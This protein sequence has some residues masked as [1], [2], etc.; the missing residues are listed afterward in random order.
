MHRNEFMYSNSTPFTLSPNK[1]QKAHAGLP[2]I[3]NHSKKNLVVLVLSARRDQE[4]RDAIRDSWA[5]GYDNVFFIVGSMACMIPPTFRTSEWSCEASGAVSQSAQIIHNASVAEEDKLLQ[6]EICREK[7]ILVPVVD[8]YRALPRK[9]KEA[10]RWALKHTEAKWFHK[11]DDDAVAR[12][13]KMENLLLKLEDVLSATSSNNY[14]VMGAIKSTDVKKDGKWA[15]PDY[16][17]SMYPWYVNGAQG[18]VVSRAL[19]QA[20]V[21]YDSTEYQGE[22]VSLGIWL[23][24]MKINATMINSPLFVAH[25]NCH[26]QGHVS[27]GHNISPRKMREC[28]PIRRIHHNLFGSLGS[29]LFQW[30]S[31]VGIAQLNNMGSC[32]HGGNLAM[33]FDGFE[34]ANCVHSASEHQFSEKGKYATFISFRTHLETNVKGYLRSYKYFDQN[35]RARIKFKA[36]VQAKA[37][38]FM[39]TF[40]FNTTV[41]IHVR[42]EGGTRSATEHLRFPPS[43]FFKRAMYH[44][45]LKNTATLFLVVSNDPTWCLEQSFFQMSDV[46][47]V[48]EKHEQSV[49]MAILARCDH[50]VL[51][52]GT[53]GWWSAFLGADIRGGE[54]VYYDS[55]FDMHHP[56]NK[57]NVVPE[58]YY[59]VGWT[60]LGA[61]GN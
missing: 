25:G 42:R 3:L 6:A 55:V 37:D 43:V 49:Y 16:E 39:Q 30:A 57:G 26:M 53:F 35:T 23:N 15:D 29:Q 2:L 51:T 5:F 33:V 36:D 58:D 40:A 59:P 1:N 45:R 17:P 10:Y 19:A 54:V 7:L 11:I 46:F 31:T 28:F 9:L 20:V 47:V 61:G 22:D 52:V 44:F 24:E 56:I 8:Y 50:I 13:S 60:A 21:T 4:R 48:T 27:I 12:I 38:A 34:E 18:Y 32:V 14:V 41:G